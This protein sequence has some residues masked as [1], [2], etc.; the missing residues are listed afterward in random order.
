MLNETSFRVQGHMV[1]KG[2][3]CFTGKKIRKLPIWKQVLGSGCQK[4]S[5]CT[6]LL[7]SVPKQLFSNHTDEVTALISISQILLD[8]ASSRMILEIIYKFLSEFFPMNFGRYSIFKTKYEIVGNYLEDLGDLCYLFF[9]KSQ[10]HGFHRGKLEW[11]E[12]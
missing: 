2:P 6:L 8:C 5:F 4:I 10:I 3:L 7:V 1:V 9:K 12:G 11:E